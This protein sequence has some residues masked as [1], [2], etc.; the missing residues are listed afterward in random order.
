MS[1]QRRLETS[2]W[3][4]TKQAI[5]ISQTERYRDNGT[6][7]LKKDWNYTRMKMPLCQITWVFCWVC[8]PNAYF[9]LLLSWETSKTFIFMLSPPTPGLG[10]ESADA[11]FSIVKCV[12]TLIKSDTWQCVIQHHSPAETCL[13]NI[14]K[15]TLD[16]VKQKEQLIAGAIGTKYKKIIAMVMNNCLTMLRLE[17]ISIKGKE[18][19]RQ[20]R[21]Q[22][23]LDSLFTSYQLTQEGSSTG[24]STRG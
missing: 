24:H 5:R 17:N 22:N 4:D 12:N 6:A 15:R 13:P 10:R 8:H 14:V 2:V 1:Q 23:C 11:K 20:G 16:N 18:G 7:V 3:I 19:Y 9:P 21:E